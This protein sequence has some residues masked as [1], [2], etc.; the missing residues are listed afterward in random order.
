[1]L[2]L[3]EDRFNLFDRIEKQFYQASR[4]DRWAMMVYERPQ[5]FNQDTARGVA[6]G[7][8][9]ACRAVGTI[10]HNRLKFFTYALNIRHHGY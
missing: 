9:E 5:R 10:S 1:M 4:I 3:I 7:L 8:V 6:R 2:I